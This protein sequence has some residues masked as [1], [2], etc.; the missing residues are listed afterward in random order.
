M[1]KGIRRHFGAVSAHL[2]PGVGVFET[3]YALFGG[4]GLGRLGELLGVARVARED[5]DRAAFEECWGSVVGAWCEF[6]EGQRAF[7]EGIAG[8]IDEIYD[9]I[10][11]G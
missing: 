6:L 9:V 10:R 2:S 11:G 7:Q 3:P 5:G 4:G 8:E 1:I